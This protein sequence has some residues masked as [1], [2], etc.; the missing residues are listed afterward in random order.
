MEVLIHWQKIQ[1]IAEQ[2]NLEKIMV[3][4]VYTTGSNPQQKLVFKKFRLNKTFEFNQDHLR[5]EK[6]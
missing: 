2:H 3:P 6:N 1:T 5:G 4:V